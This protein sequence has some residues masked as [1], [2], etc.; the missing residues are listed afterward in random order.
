MEHRAARM[1][2]LLPGA[3]LFFLALAPPSAAGEAVVKLVTPRGVSQSFLL[4]KPDKPAAAVILFAGGHGALGLS[5]AGQ[6]R[7]GAGNFLVRSRDKFAGHDLMVTVMDAPADRQSGMNAIFRMGAAHAD[8]IGAVAARLRAEANVPVWL[9]GTSMGTFSA[10][11]GALGAKGVDGLVLTS[12]ITRAKPN[13]S[14]A[15]SHPHGVASMNLPR[16]AVPTLIV[17]HRH[18]GC[19]ITPAA[20]APKLKAR[21]TAAKPADVVLLDGGAPPRSE[22]CEAMSQHGF[23]GIEDEAVAAIARFIKTHP[24]A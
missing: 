12:T 15:G 3:L 6:M 23:L 17:S 10:A 4:I 22:P 7:W 16:I 11:G 2:Q 21:L 18:D 24:R 8:D 1:T 14:I 20:D 9:V 5:G 19:D 13:W